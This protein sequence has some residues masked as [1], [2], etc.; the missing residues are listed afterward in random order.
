MVLVLMLGSQ[1]L[2]SPNQFRG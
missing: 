1:G 2:T